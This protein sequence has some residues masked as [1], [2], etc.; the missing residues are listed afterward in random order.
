MAEYFV[1]WSGTAGNA[2]T[3]GSPWNLTTARSNWAAGDTMWFF[4]GLYPSIV[5]NRANVSVRSITKWG[6]IVTGIPANHG[7]YTNDSAQPNVIIDGFRVSGSKLDGIKLNSDS[8]TIRNCW[9]QNSTNQGV[10]CFLYKN[11]TVENCLIENNGS[12]GNNDHGIYMAGSGHVIRNNVI[13]RNLTWGVQLYNSTGDCNNCHVYN[14]I[15][16]NNT[17]GLVCYSWTGN[18]NYLY[19]NTIIQPTGYCIDASYGN[20]V[21]RNSILFG[22]PSTSYPIVDRNNGTGGF[23]VDIDY[24]IMNKH[25]S[26]SHSSINTNPGFANSGIGQYWLSTNSSVRNA[27][28]TDVSGHVLMD[29]FSQSGSINPDIGAM[30]YKYG[31]T[32]DARTLFPADAVSGANYWDFSYYYDLAANPSSVGFGGVFGGTIL[33]GAGKNYS[34]RMIS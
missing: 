32:T 11:A 8:G 6:A 13:R 14:N 20:L 21:I 10:S 1:S 34:R 30:R 12:V 29:F 31:L 7:I 28:T 18:T 16:H 25:L 5:I 33:Q 22:D 3:S 4:T 15:I 19:N 2:G 9:I 26:G 17:K 24:C 23:N 27:G